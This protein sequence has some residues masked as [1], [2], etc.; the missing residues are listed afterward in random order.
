MNVGD[1]FVGV[2]CDDSE[3]A[4]PFARCWVFPVLPDA[5]Q[6]ERTAVLHPDCIGLPRLL[7]LDRLPFKE[8]VDGYDATAVAVGVAERRQRPHG[9]G[10]GVDR[11]ASA[12]RVLGPIRDQPPAQSIKRDLAGI[13]IAPDDEQVLAW[14]PVPAG[15]EIVDPA[16]PGVETFDDAVP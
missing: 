9:L 8:V 15:R 11:L 4:H 5:A 12:L 6:A 3:G 16:V 7:A 13:M 14:C 10:L 2:G 1:E